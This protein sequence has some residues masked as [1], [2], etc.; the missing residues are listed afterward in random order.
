MRKIIADHVAQDTDTYS[1]A[2]LG[3]PP[4]AYCDWIQKSDSWG[5]A[6]ELSVSDTSKHEIHYVL[7]LIL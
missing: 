7:F 3:K 4:K 1:E 6:I 2:I 5:G